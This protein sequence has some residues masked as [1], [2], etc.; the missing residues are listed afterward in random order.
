LVATAELL[1]KRVEYALVIGQ[2]EPV[3]MALVIAEP[4][5]IAGPVVIALVMVEP[6]VM[7][8]VVVVM[9]DRYKW[10]SR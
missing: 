3:V 6:V 2:P 10:Q 8:L 7:P 5:V 1:A 4:M 9:A